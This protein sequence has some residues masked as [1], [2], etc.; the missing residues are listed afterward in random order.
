M[1]PPNPRSPRS[2]PPITVALNVAGPLSASM[3]RPRALSPTLHPAPLFGKGDFFNFGQV[4]IGE[5]GLTLRFYDSAG[6]PH[7]EE[8]FPPEL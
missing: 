1:R 5:R 8:R 7:F 2:S 4:T 3:G 6:Q